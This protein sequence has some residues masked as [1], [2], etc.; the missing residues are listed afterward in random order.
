[1][2][3]KIAPEKAANGKKFAHF[4]AGGGG[5]QQQVEDDQSTG[6]CSGVF[7]SLFRLLR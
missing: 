4:Y 1:M 2:N 6:G 5:V 7:W 3:F